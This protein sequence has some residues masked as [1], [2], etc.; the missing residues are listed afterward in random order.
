[1]A[2]LK[3][4]KAVFGVA[5]PN[6]ELMKV[7]YDAYLGEKRQVGAKTLKRGEVRGG[8]RKP[9]RQKGTGRAR[10]G[11]SR[12]PIWRGGGVAFGP[13]GNENYTKKIA[14]G[15]KRVALR[16]ALT[17][18]NQAKKIIVDDV[19]VSGKTKDAA[20]FL[21]LRKITEFDRVLLVT[22]KTIAI[23][24]SF[25]NISNVRVDS[26]KYLTVFHILNADKIIFNGEKALGATTEW[27]KGDK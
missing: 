3:L 27:L 6:H 25:N 1:M 21:A 2:D 15:A 4:D 17:L 7:A 19:K 23:L 22:E 24:R 26:P 14:R 16:Q 9:W 5:I 10:F 13:S 18:A 12:N 20:K 8:G 11:S